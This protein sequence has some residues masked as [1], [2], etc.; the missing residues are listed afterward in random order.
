[1]AEVKSN[2][3]LEDFVKAMRAD[4]F[5]NI[6]DPVRR[7]Q[8]IAERFWTVMIGHV[9]DPNERERLRTIRY[10]K[11]NGLTLSDAG[12]VVPDK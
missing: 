9:T 6:E 3:S 4:D 5:A 7:Q 11:K 10:L 8:A 1:M 12:L 2:L